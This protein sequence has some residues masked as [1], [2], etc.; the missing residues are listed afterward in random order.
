MNK[1][2]ALLGLILIGILGLI[3]LDNGKVSAQEVN[4]PVAT[5]FPAQGYGWGFELVSDGIII[6]QSQEQAETLATKT[7]LN[8]CN[9]N[10]KQELINAGKQCFMYCSQQQNCMPKA[11][12]NKNTCD[13]SL[14]NCNQ[15]LANNPWSTTL[16]TLGMPVIPNS[17]FVAMLCGT[18]QQAQLNCEC[19]EF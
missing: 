15:N 13:E 7:A 2:I 16:S 6:L 4:C 8:E 9:N 1:F 5:Q 18:Y 17:N 14:I 3:G 19:E 11:N 12:V 10:L